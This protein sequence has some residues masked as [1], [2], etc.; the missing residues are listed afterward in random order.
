MSEKDDL[1][2]AMSEGDLVRARSVIL[3]Q[4]DA[5][6]LASFPLSP[7]LIQL[8]REYDSSMRAIFQ[9]D[10]GDWK[11]PKEDDWGFD[12]WTSMKVD[13]SA[14][15]SKEK[16]NLIQEMMAELRRAGNPRFQAVSNPDGAPERV[17]SDREKGRITP[18]LAPPLRPQVVMRDVG[19]GAAAGLGIGLLIRCT[20]QGG[21][22]GTFGGALVASVYLSVKERKQ[23]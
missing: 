23:R 9:P 14:N 16:L 15:F 12:A 5:D 3:A 7:S 11:C 6:R 13:L 1:R 2:E 21:L 8:T 19:L 4:L 10:D 22:V 20:V 18:S 17:R